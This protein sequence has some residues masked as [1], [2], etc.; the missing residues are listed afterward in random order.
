VI[1]RRVLGQRTR[2]QTRIVLVLPAAR[3][4]AAVVPEAVAVVVV[5]RPCAL[6]VAV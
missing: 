3:P 6:E 5:V 4:V 1:R 2:V